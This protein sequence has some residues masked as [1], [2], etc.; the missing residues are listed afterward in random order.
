MRYPLFAVLY[1]LPNTE[2]GI[3]V[4]KQQVTNTKYSN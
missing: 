4:W 1:I 3:V 2:K